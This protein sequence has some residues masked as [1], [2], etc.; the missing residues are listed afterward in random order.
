MLMAGAC[1]AFHASRF[2]YFSS[3]EARNA[4]IDN[5]VKIMCDKFG[6][7]SVKAFIKSSPP[8]SGP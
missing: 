5:R 1:D 8:H 3:A 6:K 7:K 2:L 4:F